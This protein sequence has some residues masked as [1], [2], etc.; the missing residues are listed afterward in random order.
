MMKMDTIFRAASFLVVASGSVSAADFFPI[1]I[2]G[3]ASSITSINT[4]LKCPQGEWIV[5]D[6]FDRVI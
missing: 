2:Q 6:E 1:T 3:D 4:D 5:F